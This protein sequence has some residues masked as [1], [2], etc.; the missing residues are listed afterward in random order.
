MM[1]LEDDAFQGRHSLIFRGAVHV[2]LHLSKKMKK[3]HIENVTGIFVQWISLSPQELLVFFYLDFFEAKKKNGESIFRAPQLLVAETLTACG[4][5][6]CRLTMTGNQTHLPTPSM[7][8]YFP[9]L[10]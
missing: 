8:S 2:D 5:I 7:S 3:V 1:G 10:F 9:C 4:L 6:K